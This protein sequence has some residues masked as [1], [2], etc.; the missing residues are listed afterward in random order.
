M[1][2]L[3]SLSQT[4]TPISFLFLSL[5][6]IANFAA[7]FNLSTI[8]FDQGY[9][10]LF[11]DFNIIRSDDDKSVSLLL[12]RLSGS[13]FISSDYYNY[14]LFSANI[15][16]PSNYSAGIV[17][18]N[19]D[20]FEKTH[21]E[22]DFE[23]LG[24]IHG[25]PWRF[26]T[27]LYGNG[28]THRGREERYTLWFDPAKEFHRYTILWTS[29]KYHVSISSDFSFNF[30][31]SFPRK[32]YVD[33]V[34]IREVVRSKAMGA[35]YP[36]K[37]MSLY[38][39][40]WDASTWATNGGKYKVN[41]RFQPFVS[42]FSDLVLQGCPVDPIQQ[43]PAPDCNNSTAA[44]EAANFSNITAEGRKSM[45]RFRERYM[46][47][48]YCYDTVRYPVPPP[49]CMIVP[50]EQ[51]LFKETGKLKDALKMKFGRHPTHRRRRSRGSKR[52]S[53]VPVAQAGQAA[54]DM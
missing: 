24:N 5:L 27:N 16:L 20:V 36:S 14:G 19:G 44:L 50:S 13:G 26:Q 10:P 37:P 41:Y 54:S 53:Q 42:E 43:L 28:S 40:I 6:S 1:G 32:F 3:R 30:R 15:K 21:D 34:P 48:S 23:F 51:H 29:K 52:K 2:C 35:D 22:L 39:T 47:Y 31:F 49:E 12:N 17:M 18:S 7:A 46:Y 8:T 4:L 45:S 11:S 38:A 25:R 9:S 33:D